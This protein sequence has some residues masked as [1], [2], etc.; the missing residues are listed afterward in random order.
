MRDKGRQ[1]HNSCS[2][3][4]EVFEVARSELLHVQRS[5]EPAHNLHC[6]GCERGPFARV[7]LLVAHIER[8]QCTRISSNDLTMLRETKLDFHRE[9][10][11]RSGEPI[12]GSF[13]NYMSTMHVPQWVGVVEAPSAETPGELSE[14]SFPVLP[15]KELRVPQGGERQMLPKQEPQSSRAPKTQVQIN[16]LAKKLT[17]INIESRQSTG[18]ANKKMTSKTDGDESLLIDMSSAHRLAAKWQTAKGDCKENLERDA[19]PPKSSTNLL[20]AKWQGAWGSKDIQ[21]AIEKDRVKRRVTPSAEQLA[22]ATSPAPKSLAESMDL[23][24]P[25]HPYFNASIYLSTVINKYI[26]PKLGCGKYFDNKA[27]IIGHLNSPAHGDKS[28]QCP[29]CSRIFKSVEAITY[30]AESPGYCRIR[31]TDQ[32]GAFLDQLTGGI[33]Q[34]DTSGGNDAIKYNVDKDAIKKVFW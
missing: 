28:Y 11:K 16:N 9:L 5:H 18:F 19:S 12:K 34:A 6:P 31:E 21:A 17:A 29:K 8:G 2:F 33:V 26:C 32:Y 1:D 10:A 22:A 14:E 25:N 24:D 27:M 13:A 23:D 15:R 30:H 7:G 4:G 20:A 3:C